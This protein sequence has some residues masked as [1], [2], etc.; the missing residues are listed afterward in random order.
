ML[1]RLI[2]ELHIPLHHLLTRE[3][4]LIIFLNRASTQFQCSVNY[5]FLE[6][7]SMFRNRIVQPL[8][9]YVASSSGWVS[10]SFDVLL[11][12]PVRWSYQS[13][14]KQPLSWA[15]GKLVG[16]DSYA[17]GSSRPK[18]REQIVLELPNEYF[19]IVEL[20][21]VNRFTLDVVLQCIVFSCGCPNT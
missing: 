9:D 8:S 16:N 15:Y 10:W 13:F 11:R 20:I 3:K 19:V 6:C 1:W 2:T 14:V 21:K 7:R 4:F 17:S 5:Y 12:K 18:S